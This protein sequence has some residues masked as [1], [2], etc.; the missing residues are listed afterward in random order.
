[1]EKF[2]Y[3]KP[4]IG[5]IVLA[6]LM[7]LLALRVSDIANGVMAFITAFIPL[8]LGGC[9][10]FVLDILVVRYERWLW[11]SIKKG[12][13]YKMRRP[14][15][16]ILSFITIS[17]IIY[18]IA[19]MAVPQ[20]I[21]SLSLIVAAMPQLYVDFQTWLYQ[22]S[23]TLGIT[24]NQ[25]IMDTLNGESVVNYSR[26]LGTKG[27][28]YVVD[29]MGNILSWAFNI[30]LG[31]IFAIYMLLDKERLL[32]QFKRILKAYASDAI[33]EHASYVSRVAIQT[34]SNFFVG[35]F[36][37]AIIL[38]LMVGITLWMFNISY[39]TTIA[40]VLGLT[41]LIPML[42]FY[43]GAIMGGI[44]LLTVSPMEALIYI[45][46][47]EVLHQ[48]ETNFIYPKIVGDSVG[49]PGLWVFAAVIIGGSLA[50]VTG[51]LI[52]VPL[53]AT[54]YKLL[55]TDVERRLSFYE[56]V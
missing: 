36:I 43:I 35:Q 56:D 6:G 32:G 19:R 18:F 53:I 34:F 24:N 51:M 5:A 45:I 42:G 38:G 9:I 21:H 13:K 23:S 16:L 40:C 25:T 26:E 52:G 7:V 20:L 15:S 1:M 50:G 28:A 22:L 55:M 31:I 30:M 29:A 10:A 41:A 3:Y 17:L 27:G 12:W 47:V 8:I 2:K 11:P 46:I 14:L 33:V 39:A 4:L 44:I 48:V 37:D 54:L 49:L